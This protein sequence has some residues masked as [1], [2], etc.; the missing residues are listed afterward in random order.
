MTNR[1]DEKSFAAKVRARWNLRKSRLP[2]GPKGLP[3]LGNVVPFMRD[4]LGFC[5][6]M[7]RAYPQLFTTSLGRLQVE[8]WIN[9]P[10][11]IEEMFVGQAKSYRKD[12]ITRQ[13]IPILGR[14]LLTSEGELWRTQRKLAAPAFQ[15]KRIAT[16]AQ[17]MTECT[18]RFA[19]SLRDNEQRDLHA[20]IMKVTMEIVG[21]T[22]LGVDTEQDAE[23]VSKSLEE[24]VSYYEKSLLSAEAFLMA[25]MRTPA[26]ARFETA[27]AQLD[28]IVARIIDNA[29]KDSNADYLLA[30]LLAAR[31]EDGQPMSDRQARDEATTMLLAGHETTA[32]TITFGLYELSRHP[33]HEARLREELAQ[34]G[35]TALT[36]DD[37]NRMPFLDAVIKEV[38]R[39]YPSV[40]IIGRELLQPVELA[41]YTLPAG[42]EVVTIPYALHRDPRYFREPEQFN[43]ERWLDPSQTP[44][45]YAYIPFGLGP[46][47][48]IGGGFAKMEAALVLATLL[49]H[50]SIQCVPGFQLALKP[51]ITLRPKAGLPVIV[52]RVQQASDSQKLTAAS[53]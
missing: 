41:G 48:C 22:L 44:P 11:L 19:R 20:D 25:F 13:L 42:L 37:L 46:R 4:P 27:I 24:M 7:S 35:T 38:L 29:R 36:P 26:L 45:R 5:V 43:P 1:A 14:G 31:T 39:L 30:R 12:S 28:S 33:Q 18:A 15:P 2:P 40:W 9:D 50:V 3:V 6:A 34:F 21:K 49:Q 16:Y 47:S 32:L 8:V 52:R 17:S 51:V 53:G 23:Q 10:G